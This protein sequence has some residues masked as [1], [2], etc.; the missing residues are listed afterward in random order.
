ME[1]GESWRR[2]WT[3]SASGSTCRTGGSPLFDSAVAWVA[4]GGRRQARVEAGST[5]CS[6][7][8]AGQVEDGWDCCDQKGLAGTFWILEDGNDLPL[9]VGP[10][11]PAK[12]PRV[13]PRGGA[14]RIT[15]RGLP[16]GGAA[17]GG[18][19]QAKPQAS[20]HTTLLGTVQAVQAVLPQS[21]S[22]TRLGAHKWKVIRTWGLIRPSPGRGPDA[23]STADPRS[24][25]RD[26]GAGS[27]S[28]R[29]A[30][31][32]LTG[33]R[34]ARHLH[35]MNDLSGLGRTSPPA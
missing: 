29:P 34:L 25:L 24:P 31:L 8:R 6:L 22:P 20:D 12:A 11:S 18:N 1:G 7:D 27:A 16:L 5:A 14:T 26:T 35:G 4:L 10:G 33:S 28:S 32:V 15:E 23:D 13:Q 3:P 17:A 30:L 19:C 21:A 2:R 9:P